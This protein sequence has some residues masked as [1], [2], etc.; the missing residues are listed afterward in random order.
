MLQR[1][2]LRLGDGT[3]VRCDQ[4][5]LSTWAVDSSAWVQTAANGPWQPLREF[6]AMERLFRARAEQARPP[7]PAR[8]LPLVY[9]EPL[10]P[11]DRKPLP[12]AYA[13]PG[14]EPSP[15]EM[16]APPEEPVEPPSLAEPTVVQ[17]LA[18][19]PAVRE[20]ELFEPPSLVEPT[21]VQALADDPAVR[22]AEPSEPFPT[23]EAPVE[24]SPDERDELARIAE[25]SLRSASTEP[26]EGRPLEDLPSPPAPPE[27]PPVVAAAPTFL[28]TLE[29]QATAKAVEP[30][31][32]EAL[33]TEPMETLP[34][35]AWIPADEVVTLAPALESTGELT[36]DPAFFPPAGPVEFPVR[37]DPVAVPALADEPFG[38]DEPSTAYP[39]PADGGMLPIEL[40]PFQDEPRVI[41]LKPVT[42]EPPPGLG[43]YEEGAEDVVKEGRPRSELEERVLN[44]AARA[45][46]GYDAV[47]TRWIQR[48]GGRP[49]SASPSPLAARDPGV[50]HQAPARNLTGGTVH[51][52]G[53]GRSS[54]AVLPDPAATGTPG[55]AKAAPL[56]PPPSTHELPT[57]RL[58]AIPNEERRGD[59]Y[60]GE[61]HAHVAWL[62]TKRLAVMG[63]LVAAAVYAAASW[64]AWVPKA[65][66][67]GRE[68]FTRI[69]R[70][71][72]AKR[73]REA[74]QQA[75]EQLPH[76]APA[77][78]ESILATSPNAVLDPPEILRRAS[79]AT[80]RGLP[81]L[82]VEE[83][84]E[85]SQLREALLAS[86]RPS[87]RER[88][89]EYD[90]A[91]ARRPV[92][93][94][95][96]RAAA[97]LYARAG[98]DL[99]PETRDRLQTL[100]AKAITAGLARP[101]E[102]T[103][104]SASP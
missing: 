102:T 52:A 54:P 56:K 55:Q 65:E 1:Y 24:A 31:A 75:S 27:E 36:D 93:P 26:N 22:E 15:R 34:E 97:D 95:E 13:K 41:G 96:D 57:L 59:V 25:V 80:D 5:A 99:L 100:L 50:F 104:P 39:P 82:T 76:L 61:S 21:V 53:Q 51:R 28:D 33:V 83:A 40:D 17:A 46:S 14:Q 20:G 69:D 60:Q 12:Y 77:T 42:N 49:P 67:L 91:R 70:Y 85:L 92:F 7:G 43:V 71:D 6:L 3:V 8:P 64:E 79:E 10:P 4:H 11:G 89:K 37:T 90:E 94:F 63:P 86:L 2:K 98:A 38:A 58:A 84:E 74:L 18:D 19:D 35:Q 32:M 72:Q 23:P 103:P 73:Q 78:I 30:D 47:I 88:L 62:W 66:R 16:E 81:S 45:I 29:A 68:A 9:P 87:E 48:L 44:L 101:G